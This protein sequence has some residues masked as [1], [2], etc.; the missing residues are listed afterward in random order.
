MLGAAILRPQTFDEAEADSSATRQA[1][2]VV[3]LMAFATGL[4]LDNM[5]FEG[6]HIFGVGIALIASGVL[7]YLLWLFDGRYSIEDVEPVEPELDWGQWV[8]V[9]SYAQSPGLFKALGQF[10]TSEFWVYGVFILVSVWQLLAVMV[11]VRHPLAFAEIWTTKLIVIFAVVISYV[12]G[13]IG[14]IVIWVVLPM[15]DSDWFGM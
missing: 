13:F 5:R 1:I 10:A 2:L 8:R 7:V 12:F 15:H 9:V 6:S 14:Y 11:A 4:G 3:V